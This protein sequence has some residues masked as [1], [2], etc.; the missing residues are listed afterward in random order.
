MRKIIAAAAVSALALAGCGHVH[1]AA[2]KINCAMKVVSWYE[3]K[4]GKG[5]IRAVRVSAVTAGKA[6][7][8]VTEH[9][10]SKPSVDVAQ[11]DIGKLSSSLTALRGNL[12]PDCAG[13]VNGPLSAGL[14]A[15]GT[16]ARQESIAVKAAE[17]KQANKV[18]EASKTAEA[19]A[20]AGDAQFEKAVRA[21]VK[22]VSS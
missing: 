2:Q 22:Y 6:A 7:R 11:K 10:G 9:E 20:K 17:R 3:H 21:A 5:D 12:P 15:Y 8:I 1:H 13:G 18:E 14:A 19:A 4:G 16:V